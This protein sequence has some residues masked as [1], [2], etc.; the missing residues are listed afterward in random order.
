MSKEKTFKWSLM[1]FLV[2]VFSLCMLLSPLCAEPQKKI[3]IL[4]LHAG[5]SDE[6]EPDWIPQFFNLFFDIFDPGFFAGGPLEG[7]SCYTL[8]HYANEAE[9]G[10]CGVAQG[11]PIDIFC[12]PYTG[13]GSIHSMLD[14]YTDNNGSGFPDFDDDCFSPGIPIPWAPLTFGH[15][16]IDSITEEKIFGPHVDDPEGTGIGIADFLEMDGF[17]LMDRYSRIPAHKLPYREQILKWWLGNDTPGYLPDDT[18]LSN[19]KDR[20]Q[21]LLPDDNFVFRYGWDTYRRNVDAYGNPKY[22]ADSIETAIEELI[23]DEKVDKIIVSFPEALHANVT[24]YGDNWHDNRG[25]GV[26]AVPG[27]TYKQCVEDITDGVGPETAKDLKTFLA[28][29]PWDKHW[30]H[31]LPFIKYLAKKI[32]PSID[33]RFTRAFGGFEEYESA[34]LEMLNYTVTKY[35]IPKD[36]SLKVILSHYGYYKAYMG[37]AA[38]DCYYR[39]ADDLTSRIMEKIEDNFSW[40]AKFELAAAPFKYSEGSV[41][42]P[43]S[44]DEPFGKVLSVGEIVDASINGTYVNALGEEVSNGTDN[45]DTIIVLNGYYFID[46]FDSTLYG[47]REDALGNN[48]FGQDSYA[49]DILDQDGSKYNTDAIDDEGFTVR[50]Y[51][52]TGWPSW[53]GC[54]EDTDAC[55]N[56]PPLYKGSAQNPTELIMCGTILGNPSG[57]GREN[58]TDAAVKSIIEAIQES[59]C[60]M[61]FALGGA[62]GENGLNILRK[63]RDEV[64]RKTPEGQAIIRLYYEWGPAIEKAMEKA[65]A[66]KQEVKVMVAQILPL[67]K[68]AMD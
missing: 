7:K 51:D 25:K 4:F 46:D 36:A 37:A 1:L 27:K 47:S 29:K 42:D 9:A 59:G 56:A 20:L 13:S 41:F 50:V 58:L 3:G 60:P 39:M 19:I 35:D 18:E 66:F 64:L 38:C 33:L 5:T 49:R 61:T 8:I 57:I 65:A 17:S 43:P 28:N 6:Y 15:N 63:F 44:R 26:S 31:P 2:F 16:T 12:N 48:I 10:I 45:F 40:A 14:H 53:P 62:A 34:V 21:E 11:T 55:E 22:W 67:L 68:G 23:N 24:Q 54:L 30:E 32:K 52:G